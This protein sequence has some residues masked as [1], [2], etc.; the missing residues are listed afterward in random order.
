MFIGEMGCWLVVYLFHLHQVWLERQRDKRG[1]EPVASG[2]ASEGL[3]DGQEEVGR[4]T[5]PAAKP[6]V[7]NANDGRLKLEGNRVLLLA[8]PACCDIAGTTLMNVG[9]LFVVASST[10]PPKKHP[11][12]KLPTLANPL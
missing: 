12:V 7:P 10:S 9:L 2:E 5:N 1:Y 11:K 3:L 8:L 4:D 6:L